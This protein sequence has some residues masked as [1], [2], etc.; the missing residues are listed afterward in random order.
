MQLLIIVAGGLIIVATRLEPSGGV[1]GLIIVT[2]R[3]VLVVM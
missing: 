1:K 2:T 3:L